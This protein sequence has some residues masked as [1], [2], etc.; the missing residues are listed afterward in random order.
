MRFLRHL[1]SVT[2][3]LVVILVS[4]SIGAVIGVGLAYLFT[5]LGAFLRHGRGVEHPDLRPRVVAWQWWSSS[6]P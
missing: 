5:K 3:A 1:A 2:K 6:P 4:A